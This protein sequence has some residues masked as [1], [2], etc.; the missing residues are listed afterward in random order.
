M[1]STKTSILFYNPDQAGVNYYRTLMPA[2]RLQQDYPEDFH[3]EINQNIDWNNLD[4]LRKFNIIHGHRT[5]CDFP[6]M[7]SLVAVLRKE[8][9]KVVIDIDDYWDVHEAHPVRDIM[10]THDFTTKIKN[11]I[12]LADYVTT[13]TA[14]FADYIRP[15]NR[16]I[17]VLPNAVDDE[18]PQYVLNDKEQSERL[19]LMWL[20][21]SSHEADINLLKDSFQ[22]IQSDA[23]LRSKI[24]VHLAGFDLR[25][26]HSEMV[27]NPDM[28]R[29]LY[30]V[31][32]FKSVALTF[33][34][35]LQKA[36]WDIDAIPELPK[37]IRDRYRGKVISTFTRD[38]KPEETVWT[39]YESVF[40]SDYKLLED[41]G[42]ANF[43]KTFN[44]AAEYPN[45]MT[46][47]PYIRH[48]TKGIHQ[49]ANAY[50]VADVC[51]AP[52]K[53]FGKMKGS[54]LPDNT[55]NRYQFAKSN[56]K[57][58]EAG[59][60]KVPLIASQVPTYTAD[61]D[62]KDGKNII[63]VKPERQEKDW[64]KK[65]KELVNNPNMVTDLGE[66]AYE[67]VS[68]KYSLKSINEK[69][70]DFYKKIAE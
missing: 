57:A 48:A 3:I 29:E 15:L 65:I 39:R 9:I 52:L 55:S 1:S 54:V 13:T 32:Q 5:L 7:E 23:D 2:M 10:K 19:R 56:L 6:Q 22:R 41:K 28:M 21:G 69:R 38:I 45:Q 18:Q 26:T 58:I 50:R 11:N 20:G 60:H 66:A 4:Y 68:K 14:Q 51:L 35:R 31:E 33:M 27:V 49:F 37:S 53:V 46:T 8:G 40:T 30:S 16:N 24:Q 59:F 44:L 47:Q 42:Y 36:N 70:K 63:F 34:A 17:V 62:F 25:G 67:L 12:R 61:T 43:L 64:F